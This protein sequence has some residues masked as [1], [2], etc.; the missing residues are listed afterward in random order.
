MTAKH[1]GEEPAPR[2]E[3]AKSPDGAEYDVI[4][5]PNALAA[6]VGSFRPDEAQLDE[7]DAKIAELG[8]SYPDMVAPEL[9]RLDALWTQLKSG[10]AEPGS[11]KAFF[12]VAHDFKGQ[13]A[14]FGFP[15][16]SMVAASLC[17]LLERG[18]VAL[19]AAHAAIEAHLAALRTI[20]RRRIQGDGGKIGT[21]L[22][23]G[24]RR[25]ALKSAAAKRPTPT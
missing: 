15:L 3:R 18:A 16:V 14:S 5:L 8:N 23:D 12:Q 6:K 22:V 11:D 20:V 10:S 25:T 19:P 21:K 9:E 13:G 7:I 17:T 24:L 4:H 2:I 1:T